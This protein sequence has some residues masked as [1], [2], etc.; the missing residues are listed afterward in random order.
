MTH[1]FRFFLPDGQPGE[2]GQVR[3][4]SG[5]DARRIERVLRLRPGERVEVADAEGR[6]LD[7]RVE[8]GCRVCLGDVLAEP[9]PAAPLAVHLALTGPRADTAVEKLVEIG[10]E[11]IGPLETALKR[12]DTRTDR[13]QR[14]AAAAAAQA[15]RPRVARI[16]PPLALGAALGPVAVLLSHEDPDGTLDVALARAGRPLLLLVGPES[17]FAPAEHEAA[18]AAGVPIATL[19]DIVLRTE[20]AAIAAAVLALDR[21]G[22]LRPTMPSA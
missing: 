14:I 8:E 3:A 17:G 9:S 13:W 5:A 4:L 7:G 2:P 20:T 11:T 6:V 12:R 1:V 22:W 10:V 15:K 18:R 16:A 19:G 21:L